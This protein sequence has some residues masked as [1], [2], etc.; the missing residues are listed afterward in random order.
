MEGVR[1][2]G[3]AEGDTDTR[4]DAHEESYTFN[5]EVLLV[6]ADILQEREG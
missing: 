5:T 4:L 3:R 6:K 1:E 2:S